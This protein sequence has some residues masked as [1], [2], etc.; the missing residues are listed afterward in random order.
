MLLMNNKMAM[1]NIVTE[2]PDYFIKEVNP[3]TF[4]RWMDR[5]N[6]IFEETILHTVKKE[7]LNVSIEYETTDGYEGATKKRK[8]LFDLSDLDKMDDETVYILRYVA[9]IPPN[10]S[11]ALASIHSSRLIRKEQLS[12]LYAVNLG[13]IYMR[14]LNELKSEK[15]NLITRINILIDILSGGPVTC[16]E[17]HVSK[18]YPNINQT[19]ESQQSVYNGMIFREELELFVGDKLIERCGKDYDINIDISSESRKTIIRITIL[20]LD[21]LQMYKNY[22]ERCIETVEKYPK[23]TLLEKVHGASL[24]PNFFI[25]QSNMKYYEDSFSINV[26]GINTFYYS[27]NNNNIFESGFVNVA[28]KHGK[29]NIFTSSLVRTRKIINKVELKKVQKYIYYLNSVMTNNG[30]IGILNGIIKI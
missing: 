13:Q 9:S 21:T 3:E 4:F 2:K 18:H 29:W 26:E 22:V 6:Y 12:S 19:L 10:L 17:K 24:V 7:Y 20:L 28:K 15:N 5:F 14:R 23:I 27:K 16:D 8:H 1:I 25:Y 30:T 11:D